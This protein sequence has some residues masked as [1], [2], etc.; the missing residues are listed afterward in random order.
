MEKKIITST[1]QTMRSIAL[2][3]VAIG[4]LGVV[5]SSLPTAYPPPPPTFPGKLFTK[6]NPE[7]VNGSRVGTVFIPFTDANNTAD[8]VQFNFL[9]LVGDSYNRGFAYVL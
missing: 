6:F 7:T 3:L 8:F 4:V 2:L 9:D 1:N 5:A